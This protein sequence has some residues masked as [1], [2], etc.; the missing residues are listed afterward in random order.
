MGKHI[1]S[2]RAGCHQQPKVALKQESTLAR[3]REL[4]QVIQLSYLPREGKAE[5]QR[6]DSPAGT[7]HTCWSNSQGEG[8]VP[9]ALKELLGFSE[10][11][12]ESKDLVKNWVWEEEDPFWSEKD[13]SVPQGRWPLGIFRRSM[14]ATKHP[15][16]TLETT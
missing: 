1:L 12:E 4:L 2:P 13:D 15:H 16:V 6:H 10:A 14:Y 9:Q 5:G 8:R 3:R 7:T 11:D